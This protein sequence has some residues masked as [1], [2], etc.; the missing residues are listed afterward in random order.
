MDDEGN[1]GCSPPRGVDQARAERLQAALSANPR[2]A[3]YLRA[4]RQANSAHWADNTGA[5]AA[6]RRAMEILREGGTVDDAAAARGHR[7]TWAD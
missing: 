7:R 1:D 3:M 5:G 4:E 2:A 6:G